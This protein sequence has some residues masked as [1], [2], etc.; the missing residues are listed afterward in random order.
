MFLRNIV[1]QNHYTLH[2][3]LIFVYMTFERRYLDVATTPEC[4][5]NVFVLAR[6]GNNVFCL[7]KEVVKLKFL[8]LTTSNFVFLERFYVCTYV[9]TVKAW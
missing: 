5:P 4:R 6:V 3:V 2:T 7:K 9:G 8:H 1:S